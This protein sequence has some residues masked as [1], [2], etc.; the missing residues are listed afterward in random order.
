MT[1]MHFEK[2]TVLYACQI[3]ISIV[4]TAQLYSVIEEGA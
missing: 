4:E 3:V 1:G 2:F